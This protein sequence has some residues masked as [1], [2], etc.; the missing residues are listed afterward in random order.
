LIFSFLRPHFFLHLLSSKLVSAILKDGTES[1]AGRKAF[2]ALFDFYFADNQS[3]SKMFYLKAPALPSA[4][5]LLRSPL[6]PLTLLSPILSRRRRNSWRLCLR[7]IKGVLTP[8]LENI[9]SSFVVRLISIPF[10]DAVDW[11]PYVNV[12]VLLPYNMLIFFGATFG[13]AMGAYGF[14]VQHFF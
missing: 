12:Q 8:S 5:R 14:F 3:G 13:G 1:T 6:S 4:A 7:A 10:L 11:F 9:D 2:P